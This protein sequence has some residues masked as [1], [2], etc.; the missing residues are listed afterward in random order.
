MRKGHFSLPI[1]D[2]FTRECLVMLVGRSL[3]ARDVLGALAKAAAQRGMPEHLRSNNGPEFI[4]NQVKQWLAEEGTKTLSS[5]RAA[6]GR[7][8]TAS[9]STA[10]CGTNCST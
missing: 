7:V 4:A 8:R 2:E 3:G 5:S 10:A 9:R 6:R 1:V